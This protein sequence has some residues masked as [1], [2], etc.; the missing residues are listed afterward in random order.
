MHGL[1]IARL[2]VPLLT[3]KGVVQSC[4]SMVELLDCWVNELAFMFMQNGDGE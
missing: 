2:Q 4:S 3:S 1:W